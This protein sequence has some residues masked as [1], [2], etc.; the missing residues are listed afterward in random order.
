[1][2][3]AADDKNNELL[4]VVKHLPI[5]VVDENGREIV[6]PDVIQTVTQLATLAQL[7]KIRRS[8]EREHI[9]GGV[10]KRV[11]NATEELQFID[12]LKEWPYTP[13]ATAHFW[14]TK[15]PNSV[16]IAVNKRNYETILEKGDDEEMDFTKADER[17]R[18][19]F[20][21][22]APGETATVDVFAKF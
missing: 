5:Q 16:I 2:Q 21:N 10:D 22:C 20:Y 18:I 9:K 3:N 4:P 11:L 13:W 14:N 7:V 19:I 12:L 15:G 17:I 6:R 8:L 1:M